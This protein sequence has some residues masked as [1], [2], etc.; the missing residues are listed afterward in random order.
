MGLTP[1]KGKISKAVD[2]PK[3]KEDKFLLRSRRMI[4]WSDIY[5]KICKIYFQRA[6]DTGDG[7]GMK[8]PWELCFSAEDSFINMLKQ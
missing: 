7:N 6:C 2:E 5:Q 1:V 3:N 4:V 8:V